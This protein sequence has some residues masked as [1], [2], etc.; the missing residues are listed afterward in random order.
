MIFR[1]QSLGPVDDDDILAVVGRNTEAVES[2]RGRTLRLRDTNRG[3]E[4]EVAESGRNTA[5]RRQL[6]DLTKA[7]VPIYGRPVFDEAD[8]VFEDI[9][10]VRHFARTRL[11]SILLKPISGPADQREG[12]TALDVPVADSPARPVR[13]RSRLWLGTLSPWP[14]ATALANLTAARACLR[15]VLHAP[16]LSDD[17]VDALGSVASALVE[18]YAPGAPAEVR[19]EE[20]IRCAGWIHGR[21]RGGETL[22]DIGNVL[23]R[24][25]AAGHISALRHSGSMALLSTWKVHRG[26]AF[27]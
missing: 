6:Q 19:N 23:T 10:G 3:L 27:G 24:R 4:F 12:W 17:R 9:D 14:T 13:R 2:T 21:P 20:T 18:R 5:A 15:E 8:S 11:R 25:W 16:G 26:G 1:P 22:Q 7:R